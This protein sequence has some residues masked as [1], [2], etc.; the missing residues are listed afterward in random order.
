[1]SNASGRA[2]T[3][4]NAYK[5]SSPVQDHPGLGTDRRANLHRL[6]SL[7]PSGRL[8]RL[9][10]DAD[11]VGARLAPRPPLRRSPSLPR[12]AARERDQCGC[13]RRRH[14][15]PRK[16]GSTGFLPLGDPWYRS[17]AHTILDPAAA[18]L[19]DGMGPSHQRLLA[20]THPDRA[21][22]PQPHPDPRHAGGDSAATRTPQVSHWSSI[23]TRPP[24]PRCRRP[25]SPGGQRSAPKEDRGKLRQPLQGGRQTGRGS[26]EDG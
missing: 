19:D 12:R 25:S 22:R 23:E 17:D 13:S 2:S 3:P 24:S 18:A 16:R 9:C 4:M 6:G 7:L 10:Q 1:M 8:D 20:R 15:L 21:C 14:S 26:V 11:R 5:S